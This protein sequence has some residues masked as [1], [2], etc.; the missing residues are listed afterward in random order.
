MQKSRVVYFKS[1]NVMQILKEGYSFFIMFFMYVFGILAGVLLAKYYD[2][3]D[4]LVSKYFNIPA[5]DSGYFDLFFASFLRWLPFMLLVF[6]FGTC[7]VGII[8][9]PCVVFIKGVEYGILSGYIYAAYSFSGIVYNLILIIPVGMIA[10]FGLFF[11]AKN[12]FMFS[13][14]LIKHVMPQARSE[15]LYPHLAYFC[16]KIAFLILITVLAALL[17]AALNTAF[18]DIIKLA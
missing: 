4:I 3:A 6:I 11:A 10:V 2:N 18:G 12:S 1:K 15:M 7:I 9:V 5:A 17:D 16:K 13:L 8:L 14:R